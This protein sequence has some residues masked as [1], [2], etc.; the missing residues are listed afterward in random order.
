MGNETVKKT[1]AKAA[2]G[3]TYPCEP[4]ESL[5]TSFTLSDDWVWTLTMGVVGDPSRV[6]TVRAEKPYM[7]IVP[8]TESW[9][10]HWYDHSLS[11]TAWEL[12]GVSVAKNYPSSDQRTT[13]KISNPTTALPQDTWSLG[14]PATCPGVPN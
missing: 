9:S 13:V 2:T 14:S 11:N 12:Y 1:Q 6:S 10:E 3:Q 4:G 8:G 7:G 5:F